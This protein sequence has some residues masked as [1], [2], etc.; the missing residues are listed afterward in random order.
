MDSKADSDHG[1]AGAKSASVT[2]NRQ[3]LQKTNYSNQFTKGY[4]TD[5]NFNN[6]VNV[7]G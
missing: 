4:T 1:G 6:N 3:F 2:Q 7:N 5:K